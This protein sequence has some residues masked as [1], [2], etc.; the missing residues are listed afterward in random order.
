MTSANSG[1][2][3]NTVAS[4]SASSTVSP[5]VMTEVGDLRKA[6]KVSFSGWSGSM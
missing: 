6:L 2:K 3:W 5:V 1:S 4:A